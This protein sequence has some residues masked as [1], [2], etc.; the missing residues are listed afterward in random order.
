MQVILIGLNFQKRDAVPLAAFG[1]EPLSFGL[2]GRR[3]D[4]PSELGNPHQMI[5]DG[6]VRVSGFTDLQSSHALR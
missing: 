5:G 3:K 6:I 1:D 2:D 4:A